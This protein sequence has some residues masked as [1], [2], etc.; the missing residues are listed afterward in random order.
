MYQIRRHMN[1]NQLDA[2]CKI[3]FADFRWKDHFTH[4]DIYLDSN[5]R[6]W[7]YIYLCVVATNH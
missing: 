7:Q 6:T 2:S 4:I 5:G 3:N 1:Y